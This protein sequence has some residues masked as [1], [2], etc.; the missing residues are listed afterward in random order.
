MA[1]RLLL[2]HMLLWDDSNA[3]KSTKNR[4]LAYEDPVSLALL[5]ED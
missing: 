3:R 5:E 2:Y 1:E 4:E